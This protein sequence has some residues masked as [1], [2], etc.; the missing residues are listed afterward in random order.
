MPTDQQRAF[1]N[2]IRANPYDDTPR[3]VYAD[4]LQEHGDEPRA[5]FIRVQCALA[6]LPHDRRKSRTDRKRLESRERELLSAHRDEWLAPLVKAAAGDLPVSWCNTWAKDLRFSRGFITWFHMGLANGAALA[7]SGYELEPTGSITIERRAADEHHR[8]AAAARWHCHSVPSAQLGADELHRVAIVAR[9]PFGAHLEKFILGGANDNEVLAVI[10][11]W[12]LTQLEGL[13]L[14]FG[15]VSDDAVIELARSPLLATLH[16]L[17]LTA[18]RIGDAGAR[19]LAESPYLPPKC[20]LHL[21]LNPIGDAGAQALLESPRLSHD[22][23]LVLSANTLSEDA[24]ARL[25][26]RFSRLI[27]VS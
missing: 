12:Q 20:Y 23:Y 6:R 22:C 7:G 27:L 15:T 3:L 14:S 18:N 13:E 26:A 17:D 25:K 19:A 5:E 21:H 11:N 1:W 24:R 8:E 4:W 16:S 9:W 2:A 10:A